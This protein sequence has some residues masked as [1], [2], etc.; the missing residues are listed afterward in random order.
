MY[1]IRMFITF[2]NEFTRQ[3]NTAFNLGTR[4]IVFNGLSTRSTLSDLIVDKLAPALFWLK[5]Q[6]RNESR[7]WPRRGRY[8]RNVESH[9][10][11]GADDDGR[12]HDVP[13]LPQIGA[14]VEYD[15]QIDD[16]EEHLD[17]EHSS[18]SVI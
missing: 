15:P 7:G 14:R 16:L 10:H 11:Q 4:L 18:E 8:L 12:V 5:H 2:F 13:E 9:G 1:T 6:E 3:S 17:G